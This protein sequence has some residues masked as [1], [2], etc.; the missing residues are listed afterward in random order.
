M[1]KNGGAYLLS[2]A[3]AVLLLMPALSTASILSW[4]SEWQADSA[5]YQV[6]SRADMPVQSAVAARSWLWGPV[7]FAVANEAYGESSTGLRLVEYL[8]KGRMEVNDPGGNRTT[9]WFVTSGLLVTEMVTGQLQTGNATF[10]QHSPAI[11]PIAGDEGVASVPTYA[12]FSLLLGPAAKSLA[13]D[14]LILRDGTLSPLS[15]PG[16]PSLSASSA[17][18]DVTKHNIPSVFNSWMHSSGT[19]FEDG[20]LVNGLPFDPLYVLG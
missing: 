11:V 20:K 12:S 14:K 18:D 2:L 19:V 7:P 17:Y 9:S 16:D 6:W 5:F 13:A 3:L 8:D 15:P 10:E 1:R 4:P